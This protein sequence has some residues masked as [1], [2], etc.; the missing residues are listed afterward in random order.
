MA[1]VKI[2]QP[3]ANEMLRP[4]IEKSKNVHELFRHAR[5]WCGLSLRDLRDETGIDI[6]TLSMFENGKRELSKE[7]L[8]EISSA[9][10]RKVNA[11]MQAIED[12]RAE[13]DSAMKERLL[14]LAE[15]TVRAD[16]VSLTGQLQAHAV[17]LG[18]R[19]K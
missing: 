3:E 17:H 1:K 14:K 15:I 2:T 16:M 6:A 12:K 11:D 7:S 18:G 19:R 13:E 10:G 9:I 5:E 4:L 8:K